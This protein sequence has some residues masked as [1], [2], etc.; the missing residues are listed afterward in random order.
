MTQAAQFCLANGE[1]LASALQTAASNGEDDD[2]R[3]RGGTFTNTNG[4]P[5]AFVYSA[6]ENRDFTISGGWNAGCTQFSH[7]TQT[8]LDGQDVHGVM[9][10]INFGEGNEVVHRIS[11]I[12]F[13]NGN[14][15]GSGGGLDAS[16]AAASSVQLEIEGN[17]FL[18]NA[19]SS[20]GG[21]LAAGANGLFLLRNNVFLVNE[22]GMNNGAASL[23]CNSGDAVISQNTIIANSGS[24]TPAPENRAGGLRI[25]GSCTVDLANN[26]IW[27]NSDYDLLVQGSVN[28][29][30]HNNIQD[31][32]GTAATVDIGNLSV[33]PEYMSGLL[34]FHPKPRSPL[35]NGGHPSPPGGL[36]AVDITGKARVA[37]GIVDIGAYES[38]VLFYDG[39]Q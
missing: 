18:G 19:A 38:A 35:F 1:Q 31:I 2:I 25:A 9:K 17:F 36:P 16:G 13:N 14:A 15:S 5:F 20:F 6:T 4:N 3:L 24:D 7:G 12:T 33:E 21:G 28:N 32:G 11:R 37:A 29:R 22:A 10:L 39:F 8:I 23:T 27:D 34:N 26:L 30:Y